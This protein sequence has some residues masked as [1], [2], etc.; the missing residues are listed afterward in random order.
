MS[1]ATSHFSPFNYHSGENFG[2][3]GSWDRNWYESQLLRESKYYVAV[4]IIKSKAG[5]G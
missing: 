1:H 3:S 2:T 4:Q 5:L